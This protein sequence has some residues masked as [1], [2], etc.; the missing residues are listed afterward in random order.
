MSDLYK[1][2]AEVKDTY[3]VE[4]AKFIG[5]ALYN[6]YDTKSQNL[7]DVWALYVSGFKTKG[8][9]IEF[10]AADGVNGSNTY[11]LE[12]KYG[13]T[14]VVSEPLPQ[15]LETLR[16]NRNCALNTE[17]VWT[18]TGEILPFLVTDELDLSTISGYGNDEHAEKRKNGNIIEVKSIS[19]ADLISG[20]FVSTEIDYMSV[21]TE[22][23]EY[24]I[25]QAYF[26]S[27]ASRKYRIN[28]ITVEHNFDVQKRQDIFYLMNQYGYQSVFPEFS[29]WD[30]FYILRRS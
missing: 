4:V 18:K 20:Y 27:P 7:Q 6:L 12:K 1:Y 9:F 3:P 15:H 8:K 30:D 16:A 29:R 21:D 24:D 17:C 28:A 22:G 5:A 10:G 14:G 26:S 19:L 11:M 2:L 25:L 13:W 23:S